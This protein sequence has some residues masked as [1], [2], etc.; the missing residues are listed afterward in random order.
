MYLELEN[1]I[2]WFSGMNKKKW[3]IDLHLVQN[4][5][6]VVKYNRHLER[7]QKLKCFDNNDQL[8][9]INK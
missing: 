2:L 4:F 9:N 1:L 7:V 8:E 6:N 5:K 3:K